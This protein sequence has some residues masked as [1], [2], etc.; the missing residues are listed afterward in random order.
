MQL[1]TIFQDFE[2][3]S[4]DLMAEEETSTWDASSTQNC[5]LENR[6]ENH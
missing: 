3:K 2:D 5:L 1:Y 6:S 4:T